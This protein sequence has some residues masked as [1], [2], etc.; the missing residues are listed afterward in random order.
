MPPLTVRCPSCDRLLE[1]PRPEGKDSGF[2]FLPR[3]ASVNCPNCGLVTAHWELDPTVTYQ[4]F[5]TAR[6]QERV[7][8]FVLQR[9]L[10]QGSAGEVWLA[11]DVNLNRQVALKL[12]RSLDPEMV[13]LLFEA[14]TAASLRHPHIVSVYEVGEEAGQVFI[15]TEYIDGLTLRDFLTAGKPAVSR[16]VDLL[17]RIAQALHYAHQHGVVH[18]DVKPANI[19][20]NKEG[21]PY[22]TDFGIAKRLNA[23][24]T[25]SSD[26]QV[27]GTARY[28]SPE[29]A[30]GRTKETDSRSDVYA[31]GVMLFE[32]LTGEAP[33]RG[34]VRA[35]L[36]QKVSHDPPSPRTYDR[37]L[38]KD[39]ETICLK[40]LER[41]PQKRYQSALELAEELRRFSIG[42]PIRA[43]PIS[44]V[45]RVWRW[46]R[47]RPVVAGLLA[48]LFLSPR[49][50]LR[51][52]PPHC[53][54]RC[55]VRA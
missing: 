28:M 4:Q 30:A 18:R 31:L 39:L 35:I 25:I 51:R 16:T 33:F 46:C 48:S 42:E 23:E 6:K 17:M 3:L 10:G 40:C 15:A 12:P 36:D 38:P 41:E 22:V 29:Q 49:L 52:S 50:R 34:N 45:E 11:D 5:R 13:G 21:E 8:H 32:M 7:G 53:G 2:E 1:I 43:R 47:M 24:A 37:G 9:L 55:T 19:L 20:L 44:R 14:K 26:G 54:S 27:I